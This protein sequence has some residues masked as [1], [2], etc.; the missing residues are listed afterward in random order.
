MEQSEELQVREMLKGVV[1][2]ACPAV[3]TELMRELRN[4]DVSSQRV[5]R[6]VTRDV[7]LASGVIK[8]ASSPFF[9]CGRALDSIDEAIRVLGFARLTNLVLIELLRKNLHSSDVSLSR[10]WDNSAYTAAICADLSARLPGTSRDTAYTFGLF[11]DCGIPLMMMRFS[12]YRQVLEAANMIEHRKFT[13]LEDETVG[14]NHAAIG[15]LV[16]RAWGLSEVLCQGILSH[17]DYSVLEQDT[18]LPGESCTLIALNLIA[19]YVARSFLTLK[20]DAEWGKGR[21]AVGNYLGLSETELDD[22]VEDQPYRLDR[23]RNAAAN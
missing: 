7:G 21:S 14:T 9:G 6:L 11:H 19:E 17:H 20:H 3:L 15:Y 16:A 18:G 5:S 2:P 13:D 8:A 23:A 22:L 12:E 10:F 1:I 4:D